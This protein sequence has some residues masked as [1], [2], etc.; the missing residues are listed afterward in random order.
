MVVDNKQFHDPE[1]WKGRIDETQLFKSV[2]NCTKDIWDDLCEKHEKIIRKLIKGSIIDIGC[3]WGKMTEW[4][5][6]DIIYTG[7][8]ITQEFIN[9]A[10]EKYPGEIFYKMD[11]RQ[12][13]FRSRQFDWAILISI[14]D[15]DIVKEAKRIAKKVLMLTYSKPEEYKILESTL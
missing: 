13:T 8:D 5:S 3:S 6:Y 10:R 14:T 9:M 2:Y 7:I 12:T 4:L 11:A 15:E 1:Y